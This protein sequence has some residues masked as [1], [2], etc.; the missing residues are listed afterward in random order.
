MFARVKRRAERGGVAR[1]DTRIGAVLCERDGTVAWARNMA[2]AQAL[3][4]LARLQWRRG[5]GKRKM[6]DELLIK[7]E[8]KAPERDAKLAKKRSGRA[9]KASELER[10]KGLDV[11]SSYKA[12]KKMGNDA[13]ADQ[14]KYWKLVEKQSGFKTSGLSGR[15]M[16]LQLQTLIF[17]KFGAAA[18]DLDDNDSGL[19]GR[20]EPDG[21]RRAR[22]VETEDGDGDGKGGKG[23]KRKK[24]A[25]NIVSLH[26]WEWEAT[27]EFIIECIIGKM[28]AEEGVEIPYAANTLTRIALA[29]ALSPSLTHALPLALSLALHCQLQFLSVDVA[30]ARHRCRGRGMPGWGKG[31][32]KLGDVLYKCLWEGF[33]PEIATWEDEEI[34]PCGEVDF[35]AD[36]EARSGEEEPDGDEEASDVEA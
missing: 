21:K 2:Q 15:D 27:E 8:E 5:S 19:E 35:I 28:V 14:L 32:I 17:D 36:F 9:K 26:G 29:H 34:I 22:K 3:F 6:S 7:G 13:L 20:A 18:N 1:H 10:L 4:D 11:V 24:K 30:W 25:S 12:L 23:K 16:R 31:D 33:P